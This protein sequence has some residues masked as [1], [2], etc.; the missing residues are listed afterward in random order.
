MRHSS[1]DSDFDDAVEPSASASR[2][3]RLYW[4]DASHS[5]WHNTMTNHRPPIPTKEDLVLMSV[6]ELNSL[7]RDLRAQLEW[8]RFG[9]VHKSVVKRLEVAEKVRALAQ[10]REAAVSGRGDR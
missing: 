2:N 5:R 4:I 9:P 6:K 8:C 10:D 3:S 7:I 1:F